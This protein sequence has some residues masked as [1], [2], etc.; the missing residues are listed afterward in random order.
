MLDF[1]D[2]L[3][4]NKKAFSEFV[5]TM[6]GNLSR[7]KLSSTLYRTTAPVARTVRRRELSTFDL[8]DNSDYHQ[9]QNG[10]ERTANQ[11]L[12]MKS[13]KLASIAMWKGC[14]NPKEYYQKYIKEPNNAHLSK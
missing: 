10:L 1:V 7:N 11:T 12:N 8:L 4:D 9:S 2:N 5:Q 3:K 13:E 14:L 6:H